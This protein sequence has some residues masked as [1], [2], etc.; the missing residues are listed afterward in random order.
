MSGWVGHY[1]G[2]GGS[3]LQVWPDSNPA[4]AQRLDRRELVRVASTDGKIGARGRQRLRN[5][6]ADALGRAVTKRGHAGGGTRASG[7]PALSVKR[8]PVPPGACHSSLLRGALKCATAIAPA[9]TCTRVNQNGRRDMNPLSRITVL[10]LLGSVIANSQAQPLV[11]TQWLEQNLSKDALVVLDVRSKI[12]GSKPGAFE[13]THVPGAVHSDYLQAGWRMTVD[14]VPGMLPPVA[15][16]EQLIGSLGIDNSAH[17]VV[18]TA[19]KS[20]LDY[21]SATRVYWTFKV[22]GHDAVSILD[23]GH[24]AWTAQGR[25]LESGPSSPVVASFKASFRP[26]LLATRADVAAAARPGSGVALIDNRPGAQ[27]SGKA[28]FSAARRA[29]RIPQ[30]VNLPQ[31]LFREARSGSF[32]GPS[33]LAELW[34]AAGVKDDEPQIA[35]CNTGHWASLGWFASSELLGK[36]AKLYDGSMIEWANRPELPMEVGAQ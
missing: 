35:Y 16:L 33:K 25:P 18:V 8:P 9:Y 31:G 29:G 19:G 3:R 30:A 27:Y 22:L 6:A 20:A 21:G 36:D 26:E 14:G 34:Q 13:A 5:G 11:G 2:A 23:G 28:K 24:F 4:P 12:D 7:F 10:L 15:K 1:I 17:V 32:T